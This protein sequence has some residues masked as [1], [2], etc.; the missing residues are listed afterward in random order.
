[1]L[2]QGLGLCAL[3]FAIDESPARHGQ[4]GQP[5]RYR[6]LSRA[7]ETLGQQLRQVVGDP[8]AQLL[9]RGKLLVRSGIL[10]ADAVE[11]HMQVLLPL[12]S[13]CLDIDQL[14]FVTSELV[15]I[16]QAGHLHRGGDPA[17]AL[18]VEANE[19]IALRQVGPVQFTRWVGACAQ[20]E[21]HGRQAQLRDGLSCRYSLGG[22]LVER[23]AD[24]HPHALVRRAD[25]RMSAGSLHRSAF[26]IRRMICL[27][28]ESS[29]FQE[30]HFLFKCRFRKV[31]LKNYNHEV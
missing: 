20:L 18:P 30:P 5:S 9:G 23:R 16:L 19:D 31:L 2:Q 21:K 13:G 17:I 26:C 25:H 14:G 10:R 29:P 8:L 6:G 11:Q 12:W 22:Q 24:K 1:M 3:L 28:S 15:L 4:R 27:H 7:S